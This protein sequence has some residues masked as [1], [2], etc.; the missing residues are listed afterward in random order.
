VVKGTGSESFIISVEPLKCH[1]HTVATM[2]IMSP[3]SEDTMV[4][5]N[6]KHTVQYKKKPTANMDS[7]TH[8]LSGAKYRTVTVILPTIP[9]CWKYLTRVAI[10]SD[11]LLHWADM[12]TNTF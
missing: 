3:R 5:Y 11:Y 10:Y 12:P 1:Y 4:Q 8:G 6:T 9:Q 7:N 2:W